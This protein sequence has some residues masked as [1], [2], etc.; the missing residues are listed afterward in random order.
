MERKLESFKSDRFKKI[1]KEEQKFVKGGSVAKIASLEAS[2]TTLT[3]TKSS[4][5]TDDMCGDCD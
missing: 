5:K 2:C 4:G 3:W 1:R